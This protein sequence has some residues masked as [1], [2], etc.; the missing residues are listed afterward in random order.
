VVFKIQPRYLLTGLRE[1]SFRTALDFLQNGASIALRVTRNVCRP[2]QEPLV[3]LQNEYLRTLCKN[4]V[5]LE[6]SLES[7]SKKVPQIH[8]TGSDQ[9]F[10]CA[11]KW[12]VEC[13]SQHSNCIKA[14]DPLPLLPSRV[15][16]VGPAEGSQEPIL[17]STQSQRG[18]YVALSHRWGG[19][20]ITKT[21]KSNI[22]QRLTGI[23]FNDLT[24]QVQ[25]ENYSQE[26]GS[27]RK[28]CFLGEF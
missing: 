13:L 2:G 18:R 22:S 26:D 27:C 1:G 5:A 25:E 8:N 14:E 9:G 24:K 20:N 16:D 15:I 11:S 6:H 28:Y 19:S 12:L 17:I 3:G 23:D 4:I 10:L 7:Q 21:T